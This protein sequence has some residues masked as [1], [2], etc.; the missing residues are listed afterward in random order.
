M[1]HKFQCIIIYL[2]VNVSLLADASSSEIDQL[3]NLS[4][5]CTEDHF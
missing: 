1:G 5:A 2:L 3:K 4:Y